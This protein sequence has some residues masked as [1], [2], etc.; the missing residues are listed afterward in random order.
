M[1]HDHPLAV[2]GR[3]EFLMVNLTSPVS[4]R[5][6]GVRDDF[7]SVHSQTRLRRVHLQYGIADI[8]ELERA[9]KGFNAVIPKS[10][11]LVSN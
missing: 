5:C 7:R 8:L 3:F 1:H 6:E 9:G 10:K 11:R 2:S 4:T